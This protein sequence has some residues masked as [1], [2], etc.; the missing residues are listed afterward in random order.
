MGSRQTL[1][2]P[3]QVRGL[4]LLCAN[5]RTAD[6]FKVSR[7]YLHELGNVPYANFPPLGCCSKK[8]R[9]ATEPVAHDL[10]RPICVGKL[11]GAGGQGDG[12]RNILGVLSFHERTVGRMALMLGPKGAE[13]GN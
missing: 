10:I 9:A 1:N 2:A 3:A 6:G 12:E 4:G 11:G 5:S 7:T 13:L 8:M